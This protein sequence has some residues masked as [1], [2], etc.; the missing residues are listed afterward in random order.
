MH[1]AHCRH[2]SAETLELVS[3][4][5]TVEP[6]AEFRS[7][8]CPDWSGYVIIHECTQDTVGLQH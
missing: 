6:S 1:G 2:A 3:P 8:Q 5:S 4:L 7:R